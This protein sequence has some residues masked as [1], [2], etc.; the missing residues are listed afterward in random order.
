M[1]SSNLQITHKPT[2]IQLHVLYRAV[3]IRF[4]VVRFVVL[5]MLGGS[6]GMLPQKN[7]HFWANMMLL[8]GQM[9]EFQMNEYLPFLPIASCISTG[10]SFTIQFAYWLKATPFTGGAYKQKIVAL[11]AAIMQV[12]TLFLCAWGCAWMS[13]CPPNNGANG[14]QQAIHK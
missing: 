13:K 12:S 1:N 11:L 8:R 3:A 10:F 14:Q 9:T 6:G 2:N 7:F 5:Y 4:G